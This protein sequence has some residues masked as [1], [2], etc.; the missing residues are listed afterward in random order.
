MMARDS[1]G[2]TSKVHQTGVF[3]SRH[4]HTKM[5]FKQYCNCLQW[6]CELGITV[7]TKGY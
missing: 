4:K 1:W 5:L 7:K 6:S 3:K 2:K